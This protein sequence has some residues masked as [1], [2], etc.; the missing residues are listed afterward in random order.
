MQGAEHRGLSGELHLTSTVREDG[1]EDADDTVHGSCRSLSL[2]VPFAMLSGLM[3]S[4]AVTSGEL[5]ACRLPFTINK[6]QQ[7]TVKSS[8]FRTDSNYSSS[9]D[10]FLVVHVVQIQIEFCV[11]RSWLS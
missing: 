6:A 3:G 2:M 1:S 11:A 5:C 7:L 10:K 8:S 9:I 4:G